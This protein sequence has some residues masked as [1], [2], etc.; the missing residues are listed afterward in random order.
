M[1]LSRRQFLQFF[2]ISAV[3]VSFLDL[4]LPQISDISAETIIQGRTLYPDVA[5]FDQPYGTHL[6][7]IRYAD[8]IV[9]LKATDGQW[10]RSDDGYIRHEDVQ[11]IRPYS[12]PE[13]MTT[14]PLPVFGEVISPVAA[15]RDFAD[16]TAPQITRIG[17]GG[18]MQIT[19]ALTETRTGAWYQVSDD[20]GHPLGWTQALHWKRVEHSHSYPKISCI[21][22]APTARL[23]SSREKTP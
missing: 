1:T 19:D 3:S 5:A 8:T 16:P 20:Q 7:S 15:V 14:R 22:T 18:V 4:A 13:A 11:P 17:H 12:Q 10:Y 6:H 9:P 23:T 2:G 21:L